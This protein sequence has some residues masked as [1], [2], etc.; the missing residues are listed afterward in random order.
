[1]MLSLLF[2]TASLYGVHVFV[3]AQKSVAAS[4]VVNE[5][6]EPNDAEKESAKEVSGFLLFME[7]F[8]YHLKPITNLSF[9]HGTYLLKVLPEAYLKHHTP[10]PEFS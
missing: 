7:K 10:P 1:M 6:E 8:R 3:T 2:L 5:Q 9:T 4:E